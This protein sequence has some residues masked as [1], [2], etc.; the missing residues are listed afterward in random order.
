VSQICTRIGTIHQNYTTSF[1]AGTRLPQET[2]DERKRKASSGLYS[3]ILS[4]GFETSIEGE[5]DIACETKS[6]S[7][8]RDPIEL[9]PGRNGIVPIGPSVGVPILAGDRGWISP[10]D[11]ADNA[12][13]L[14]KLGNKL[15]NGASKNALVILLSMV[16]PCNGGEGDA[17]AEDESLS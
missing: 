16:T 12:A 7:A 5:E 3:R 4:A 14:A 17:V 13:A 2:R 9:I 15:E 10:C 8:P 1:T 11:S 6:G